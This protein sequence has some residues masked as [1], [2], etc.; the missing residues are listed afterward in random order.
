MA[1]EVQ[2]QPMID[3]SNV[4]SLLRRVD[5]LGRELE[6]LR[7]DLLR[8]VAVAPDAPARKPTLFGSVQAGDVTDE[9]IAEAQQE[10]WR[11]L[12]DL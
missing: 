9:M 1:Q 6:Q 12:P 2:E 4:D 5:A 11:P 7:R 8:S 3:Q 10:L